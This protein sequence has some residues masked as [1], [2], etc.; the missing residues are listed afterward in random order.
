MKNNFFYVYLTDEGWAAK[1]GERIL[2]FNFKC[3]HIDYSNPNFCIFSHINNVG[4]EKQILALI[5]FSHIAL[6]MNKQGV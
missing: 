1:G 5:P 2:N 4:D 3:N 6:I